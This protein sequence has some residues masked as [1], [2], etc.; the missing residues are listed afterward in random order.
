MFLLLIEEIN[1]IIKKMNEN[2]QKI[3]IDIYFIF[4]G[5]KTILKL[6]KINIIFINR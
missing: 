4:F 1:K 5:I 6:K 3:L 2:K